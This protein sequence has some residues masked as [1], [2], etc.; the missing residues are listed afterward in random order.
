[1]ENCIPRQMPDYCL[2]ELDGELLLYHLNK[3]TIMYCNQSASTIWQLCDGQRRVSDMLALLAA[4]YDYDPE[5]LA[6][7]VMTVLQEFETHQ[8]IEFV[9]DAGQVIAQPST[10]AQQS[11]KRPRRK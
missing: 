11:H 8:A 10:A 6:A 7:E 4:A 1:M 9:D 2:Q 3:T 5:V